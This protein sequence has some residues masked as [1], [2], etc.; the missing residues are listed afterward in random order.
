MGG[1]AEQEDKKKGDTVK[2][3]QGNK[4]RPSLT[5]VFQTGN[6]VEGVAKGAGP[7]GL[8]CEARRQRKRRGRGNNGKQKETR[9]RKNT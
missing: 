3:H 1:K 4:G 8:A 9:I 2:C 7:H 6:K 5:D